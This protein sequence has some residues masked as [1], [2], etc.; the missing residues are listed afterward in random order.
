MIDY[1]RF[2]RALQIEAI[3]AWESGYNKKEKFVDIRG[4]PLGKMKN[5]AIIRLKSKKVKV[6]WQ[7][8]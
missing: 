1:C 2:E 5:C 6:S 3:S 8:R 7:V 4:G